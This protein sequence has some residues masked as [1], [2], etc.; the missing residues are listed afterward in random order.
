MKQLQKFGKS[1]LSRKL[2]LALVGA[3]VAFG[4]A[5]WDWGMKIEEVMSIIAPLV[6]FIGVEGLKDANQR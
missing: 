4:N 2:I 5:Y 6:A 3:F 1:L